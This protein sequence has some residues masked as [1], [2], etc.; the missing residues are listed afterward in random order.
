MPTTEPYFDEFDDEFDDDEFDE[1]EDEDEQQRGVELRV[2]DVVDPIRHLLQ[3][4]IEVEGRMP[5]S[6]NA[7]FLVHVTHDGASHP[8]I[9]KP[10]RGERP[11]CQWCSYPMDPDGHDCPRMN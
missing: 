6:S 3:G 5:Y 2:D 1:D 8:A 4:E 10:M 7:T 9:Y 11:L